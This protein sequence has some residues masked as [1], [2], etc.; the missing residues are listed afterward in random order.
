M[1]ARPDDSVLC[2]AS[3]GR[4]GRI[5]CPDASLSRRADGPSRGPI[6]ASGPKGI[7]RQVSFQGGDG[8]REGRPPR[9]RRGLPT[10]RA[11]VMR[12]PV[13]R[14]VG[15]RERTRSLDRRL[16]LADFHVH[17]RLDFLLLL[18][19][20]G[21]RLRLLAEDFP[22]LLVDDLGLASPRSTSAVVSTVFSRSSP[23]VI[24]RASWAV[25]AAGSFSSSS[26]H[27]ASMPMAPLANRHDRQGLNQASH[28]INSFGKF[29][30]RPR[31]NAT[32][33]PEASRTRLTLTRRA[34][35]LRENKRNPTDWIRVDNARILQ[36]QCRL[37]VSRP[38]PEPRDLASPPDG[39]GVEVRPCHSRS[40]DVTAGSRSCP[41]AAVGEG[42][43]PAAQAA[44]R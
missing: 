22:R 35:R 3:S 43:I 32:S 27:P 15:R 7:R 18:N 44:G 5:P 37:I 6:S 38:S 11:D 19:R 21:R 33:R 42:I 20:H 31:A 36:L 2:S 8:R 12:W 4:S 17:V 24:P 10:E 28:P 1:P 14:P 41:R 34:G 39:I 26:W 23:G 40:G 30:P 13:D 9:A 16:R 29:F 25:A